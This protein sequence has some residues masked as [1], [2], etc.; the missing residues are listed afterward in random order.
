MS[1]SIGKSLSKVQA[2]QERETKKLVEDSLS[3]ALQVGN[4]RKRR[5]D[6]QE[7]TRERSIGV[8]CFG[9]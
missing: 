2:K 9:P 5:K 4:K 1:F 7:W 6:R 8:S 3:E